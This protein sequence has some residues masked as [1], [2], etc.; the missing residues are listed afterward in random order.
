MILP[1]FVYISNFD[2]FANLRY[3]SIL[4]IEKAEN[5]L[6]P[7]TSRNLS[8]YSLKCSI[9]IQFA[10]SNCKKYQLQKILPF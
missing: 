4:K 6:D 1:R 9:I 3:L 10:K 8:L 7:K 5:I 2:I